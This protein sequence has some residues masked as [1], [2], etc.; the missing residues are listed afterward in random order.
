M[1]PLV[2]LALAL[3]TASLGLA[4]EVI[5]DKDILFGKAG[6]VELKLDLYRPK[7][8]V[9]D[10]TSKQ[11]CLVTIFGGGF[12]AGN[13]EMMRIFSE[14]FARA[15]Y[16]VIAPSYRLVPDALFPAPVEDCKCAVRWIRAHADEYRIDAD[17]IGAMGVSAGGYLSMMLGYTERSDAFEGDG[18]HAQY[19]SKVRAVVNYAGAFDL[20]LH[21]WDP[22]KEPL[23]VDFLGSSIDKDP[24]LFRKASPRTY[25]DSNDAPTLSL[26]G[27]RDPV[28]PYGQAVLV[29]TT[30]RAAGVATELKLVPGAGHGWLGKDLQETQRLAIEF[31]G[32]HLRE[33]APAALD[34]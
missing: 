23:I 19:S 3:V 18:G 22:K 31:F 11:P 14:Q 10:P 27:T 7:S 16:V 2:V 21:D 17:E 13:K 30:L 4:D 12:R 9:E 32:R 26:H 5:L 29:D 15:G 24:D 34:D 1:K 6:D 8:H 20:T 28:V 25:V 33:G